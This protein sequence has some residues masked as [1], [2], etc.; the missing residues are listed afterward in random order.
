MVRISAR[1]IV[2]FRMILIS[3]FRRRLLRRRIRFRSLI[4][5]PGSKVSF[6]VRSWLLLILIRVLFTSWI[7]RMLTIRRMRI[8]S[9]SM[10]IVR[11][12]MIRNH[13][14]HITP[15]R[16]DLSKILIYLRFLGI[17]Q[18]IKITRRNNNLKINNILDHN[19]H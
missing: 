8:L 18:V 9:P 19:Q 10:L 3:S 13:S 11:R 6:I 1:L 4:F 2:R 14:S 7:G 5:R 16:M 17:Y 12:I 15:T